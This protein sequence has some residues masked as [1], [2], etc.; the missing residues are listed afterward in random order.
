MEKSN[1]SLEVTFDDVVPFLSSIVLLGSVENTIPFA[2]DAS[3]VSCI[4]KTNRTKKKDNVLFLRLC[5]PYYNLPNYSLF[6]NNEKILHTNDTEQ[7]LFKLNSS[8]LQDNLKGIKVNESFTLIKKSNKDI[9]HYNLNGKG[10][11]TMIP[12]LDS[13]DRGLEIPR[14]FDRFVPNVSA[15]ISDYMN[16]CAML[17]KLKKDAE[18]Y[19]TVY[20]SGATFKYNNY[21]SKDEGTYTFGYENFPLFSN[22]KID[23]QTLLYPYSKIQKI[24]TG[25]GV[26]RMYG[27]STEDEEE[28]DE[29]QSN[30]SFLFAVSVPV[31]TSGYLD[32]IHTPVSLIV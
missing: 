29:N 23:I 15:T 19:V 9:I 1:L 5:F 13:S 21:G 17:K 22:M 32:I 18:L 2:C 20:V 6:S 30:S 8:T 11:N 28:N 16:F 27:F 7:L 24:C 10:D 14:E 25:K 31:G 3:K 12:V 4:V 26:I